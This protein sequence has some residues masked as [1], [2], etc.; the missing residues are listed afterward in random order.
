MAELIER[1][2]PCRW[3]WDETA[4][5]YPALAESICYQQLTGKAA[6][7][8]WKRVCALW[9]GTLAPPALLLKTPEESLRAAGLSRNK[10]AALRDLATHALAGHVPTRRASENMSDTELIASLIQVRGIGRW[11]VEMF[12]LF[13]LGRPDVLPIHDY[14]VQ[15]GF[16]KTYRKRKLPT[17]K[18]L[19]AHGKKWAPHRSVAAW[20]LWR[21]ADQ[22]NGGRA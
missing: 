10:V 11:T 4:E 20:Y 13:S 19:E 8:I 22:D 6:A 17:P 9:G 21:A 12:L 15:K 1:T 16:Q 3:K 5:P 18:Q 2:G 14:G 7:T